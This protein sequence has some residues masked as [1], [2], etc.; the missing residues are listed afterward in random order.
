MV[1]IFNK[2]FLGGKMYSMDKPLKCNDNMTVEGVL[3]TGVM[4]NSGSEVRDS[5]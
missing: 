4:I 3:N 5:F 2:Y 1:D